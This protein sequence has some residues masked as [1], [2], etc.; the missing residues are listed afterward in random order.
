MLGVLSGFGVIAVVV[1]I[2]WICARTNVLGPDG[3]LTLNRLVFFVATPALLLDSL[4][5]K[6]IGEVLT[7]VFFVSASTAVA[8]AAL[9]VC[10]ARGLLGR[11]GPEL[12]MGAMSAS[13]VNSA[14]LGIPIAL[15]VLG[16]LAFVAP[17][18]L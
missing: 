3:Q 15:Y 14:N 18:M 1:A 17:L 5:R 8:I 13:Y 12:I 11:R 16:D 10:I 4:A 6:D 7:A 9:Y 2:G